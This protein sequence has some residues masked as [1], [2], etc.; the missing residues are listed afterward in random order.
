MPSAMTSHL[1]LSAL[2]LIVTFVKAFGGPPVMFQTTDVERRP[3]MFQTTEVVRPPGL[4]KQEEHVKDCA[5]AKCKS[6]VCVLTS[7][8]R[9]YCNCSGTNFYGERCDMTFAEYTEKSKKREKKQMA[10]DK[11]DKAAKFLEEKL[12]KCNTKA[13]SMLC[14]TEMLE[15]LNP[16]STKAGACV[17]TLAECFVGLDGAVNKTLMLAYRGLKDKRC[18]A[19]EKY[20]DQEG[21]CLGKGA[22]CRPAYKCPT[23]NPFRCGDWSCAVDASGCSVPG[24]SS[25][26]ADACPKGQQLCPDG[27]CYNGT[28]GLKE[29][30]RRGVQ[31]DGCPPGKLSCGRPGICGK[32]AKEC[33][34]KVGCG[35]QLTFCG[36]QRDGKSGKVLF[37]ANIGKPLPRCV[38]P[39]QCSYGLPRRPQG[40][41][42]EL[43]AEGSSTLE[44]KTKDGKPAVAL[45]VKEGAF[46]VGGK[47]KAVNFSV[48]AVPDSLLQEGAL[49]A[50]LESGALV[51]SPIQ[52]EP[53]AEI[54]IEGAMELDIPLLDDAANADD[55]L[56]ALA[57]EQTHMLSISDITDIDEQPTTIGV[58]RQG[59]VGNCSCAV[60]VTHFSTYL[61]ADAEVA[62]R[63]RLSTEGNGDGAE[64][65]PVSSGSTSGASSL[66]GSVTDETSPAARI[67]A[68][69]GIAAWW[70]C[71]LSVLVATLSMA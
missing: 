53:S 38:R 47:Q 28:G 34:A 31:W 68:P 35:D 23:T 51:S 6:G 30:T 70:A 64:A 67:A 22:S 3:L 63:Q 46:K 15:E 69:G 58:C 44:A 45:R 8:G 13:V 59:A 33:L 19:S 62:T 25:N 71:V 20:C 42:K 29:C 52:I 50:L 18:P 4:P 57:L 21:I 16:N 2:V 37:D 48:A 5:A 49:G 65:A 24:S 60:N 32:S 41:R 66:Q 39:D 43:N 9:T 7:P 26:T 17:S 61:L 36:F 11:S 55:S 56:C 12:A 1:S 54:Q 40:M 10:L 27:L 14:P